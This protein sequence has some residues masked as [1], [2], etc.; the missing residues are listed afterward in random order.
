MIEDRPKWRL[1][2]GVRLLAE[3]WFAW[4][5]SRE[6]LDSYKRMR[7]E[8]PQLIGRTL[9]ERIVIRRSGPDAKAAAGILRRAE[10]SFCEWPSERDLK[11]RDVVRYIVVALMNVFHFAAPQGH[12]CEPVARRAPA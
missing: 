10:Q 12:W 7:H 3:I 9:Y 5:A 1:L 11:F 4:Q 6:L 8:Q 2:P